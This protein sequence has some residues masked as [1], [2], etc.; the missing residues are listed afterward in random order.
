MARQTS[1][2]HRL[3]QTRARVEADLKDKVDALALEQECEAL[4]MDLTGRMK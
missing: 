3:E 4:Q 2:I 1:D